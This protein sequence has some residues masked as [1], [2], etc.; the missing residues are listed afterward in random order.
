MIIK[1][2]KIKI[3]RLKIN[4]KNNKSTNKMKI[5]KIFIQNKKIINKV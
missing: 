1:T 4:I 5:Y 3:L 2:N